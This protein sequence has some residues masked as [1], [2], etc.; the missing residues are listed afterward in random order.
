MS[1]D[2]FLIRDETLVEEEEPSE[3]HPAMLAGLPYEVAQKILEVVE[4]LALV[5]QHHTPLDKEAACKKI[6]WATHVVA[7][8]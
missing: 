1:S 6:R 8:R 5:I 4:E 2:A 3:D 7:N